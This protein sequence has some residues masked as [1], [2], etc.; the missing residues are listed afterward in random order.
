MAIGGY[1]NS[2]RVIVNGKIPSFELDDDWVPP[3]VFVDPVD[4]FL[5]TSCLASATGL[6]PRLKSF[7]VEAATN[8]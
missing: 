3:F 2:W 8:I 5:G 6:S 4:P 7:A 1:P